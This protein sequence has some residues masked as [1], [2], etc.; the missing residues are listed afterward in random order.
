MKLIP[1]SQGFQAQVDNADYARLKQFCWRYQEGYAVRTMRLHTRRI[2]IPMQYDVLAV[3]PNQIID[4]KDRNGLNN[5][6]FNLR[7]CT[8]QQNARN[9]TRPKNNTS[10]YKGV[11]WHHQARRWVAYIYVDNQRL[12]LG[13]F[14]DKLA[15]ARRYD[16]AAAYYHAEFASL[17][18]PDEIPVR[19]QPVNRVRSTSSRFKGVCF[20]KRCRKWVAYI[21][22]NYTRTHLGYFEQEHDAALAYNQA[23][24][25]RGLRR[26]LNPI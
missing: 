8:Y 2:N 13:R 9:S 14:L 16:S 18:F 25:E 17:N 10:G 3:G 21:R 24:Q 4:H 19:F 11:T 6:R 12:H 22:Q 7:P 23:I 1:L 15:A 26:P 20:D 5:Q